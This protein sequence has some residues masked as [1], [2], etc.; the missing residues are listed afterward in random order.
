MR[1][2]GEDLKSCSDAHHSRWIVKRSK[3]RITFNRGQNFRGYHGWDI[4]T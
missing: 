1:Y 3:G 4:E 2:I